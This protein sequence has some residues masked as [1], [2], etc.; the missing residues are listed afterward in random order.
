MLFQKLSVSTNFY[1]RR[2]ARWNSY[3]TLVI[4]PKS[5]T[6]YI[7]NTC[8]SE[9]TELSYQQINPSLQEPYTF[10][11]MFQRLMSVRNSIRQK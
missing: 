10:L 8:K 4:I 9:A 7:L 11:P 3:H 2:L 6:R 1:F 5:G